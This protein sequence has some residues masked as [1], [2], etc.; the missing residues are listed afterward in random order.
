MYVGAVMQHL[1]GAKLELLFKDV[2]ISRHGFAVA[3]SSSERTGDFSIHD[4][5]VHVTS[6]PGEALIRKCVQNLEDGERP[7]I[8]TGHEGVSGAVALATQAG[9][10]DRI[11]IFEIEQFL[12]LN[13]YEWSRF[14]QNDRKIS[15]RQLIDKYNDIIKSCETDSS[16]LIEMH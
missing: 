5:K 10:E 14:I 6:A 15:I 8:V 7:I 4:V 11:D 9:I 16:L 1:V 2:E 12:A 3:D 13:V